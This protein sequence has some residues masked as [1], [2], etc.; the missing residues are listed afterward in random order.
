MGGSEQLSTEGPGAPGGPG[1]SPGCPALPSG[2]WQGGAAEWEA[3]AHAHCPR[4]W[5]EGPGNPGPGQG[6]LVG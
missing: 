4:K 2:P 6:I 1:V 3:E 5:P